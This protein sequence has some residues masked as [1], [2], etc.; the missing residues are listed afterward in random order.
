[1]NIFVPLCDQSPAR[2]QSRHMGSIVTV[3]SFVCVPWLGV[4]C[5]LD[6]QTLSQIGT[7]L[8]DP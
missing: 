3:V 4:S 1:M 7:F 5:V 6:L 8:N 2:P